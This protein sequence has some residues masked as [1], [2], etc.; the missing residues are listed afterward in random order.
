MLSSRL[1]VATQ[2]K[3]A[4]DPAR[5]A[6]LQEKRKTIIQSFEVTHTHTHTH[7]HTPS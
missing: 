2:S 1:N 5:V 4:I 6:K 7:T 3:Q